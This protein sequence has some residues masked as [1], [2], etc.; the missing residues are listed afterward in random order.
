VGAT[1]QAIVILASQL[2]RMLGLQDLE[3]RAG[4]SNGTAIEKIIFLVQNIQHFHHMTTLV[5]AIAIGVLL[6]S[7]IVRPLIAKRFRFVNYVPDVLIVVILGT[8][9]TGAL[10]WDKKGVAILGH[11]ST[12][13]IHV[14]FPL[15]HG[16]RWIKDTLPSAITIS[17]L[18]YLDSIVGAKQNAS[19]FN[20]SVR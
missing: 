20:Y 10:E 1:R 13:T 15:H 2:V 7:R 9:L 14:N 17:V 6:G 5:S 11:I 4:I 19:Q 16:F 18:G 8:A 3:A 12:G